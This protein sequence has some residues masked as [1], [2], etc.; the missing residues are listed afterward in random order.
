MN[1]RFRNKAKRTCDPHI[2]SLQTTAMS[3]SPLTIHSLNEQCQE[4][5]DR[6]CFSAN[7][8]EQEQSVT[9]DSEMLNVED[10][11][12]VPGLIESQTGAEDTS[13]DTALID[14]E[15]SRDQ[16]IQPNRILHG[17]NSKIPENPHV[18]HEDLYTTEGPGNEP[19]SKRNQASQNDMLPREYR[20]AEAIDSQSEPVLRKETQ[21][22]D[23]N[24]KLKSRLTVVDTAGDKILPC[25][26]ENTRFNKIPVNRELLQKDY[27]TAVENSRCVPENELFQGNHIKTSTRYIQQPDFN[28]KMASQRNVFSNDRDMYSRSTQLHREPL[29]EPRQMNHKNFTSNALYAEDSFKQPE[30]RMHTVQDGYNNE[31]MYYAD[32]SEER[33]QFIPIQKTAREQSMDE[34][35]F[36]YHN[37]MYPASQFQQVIPKAR[38]PANRLYVN[39]ATTFSSNREQVPVCMHSQDYVDHSHNQ[40]DGIARNVLGRRYSEPYTNQCE[41]RIPDQAIRNDR[42]PQMYFQHPNARPIPNIKMKIPTFDGEVKWNTFFRQFETVAR[43]SNWSERDRLNNL[44]SS[45]SGKAAEFVF[46]LEGY[47]LNDYRELVHHLQSRYQVVVTPETNQRLFYSRS[48]HKDE[49]PREYAASLRTL[50]LKAYQTGIS[51]NIREDMLIKQ[52]F[53]GLQDDDA[54]YAVKYLQHPR[55]LEDAVNKIEEYYTFRQRSKTNSKDS[56]SRRYH[57]VR[58]VNRSP[59]AESEDSKEDNAIYSLRQE[60]SQLKSMVNDLIKR[61]QRQSTM[62]KS[63]YNNQSAAVYDFKCFNCGEVGHIARSCPKKRDFNQTATKHVQGN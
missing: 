39:T 27:T 63:R 44:L 55:T 9:Y 11:S 54:E 62:K 48:L 33:N 1:T 49:N 29:P 25:E 41:Q 7:S 31:E 21:H 6:P 20:G 59:S 17:E 50:I 60:V 3:T 53:D 5:G 32:L 42:T 36:H 30:H 13:T 15:F 14:D 57:N 51:P 45:L 8:Q 46:D 10:G 58:S 47:I 28:T 22:I 19:Q 24:R 2:T 52:F 38:Q 56:T 26:N 18:H 43:A 35:K 37:N 4:P 12:H 40:R 16:R 61:E 34:N 23:L